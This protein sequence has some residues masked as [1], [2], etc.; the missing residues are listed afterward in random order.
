MMS[1]SSI[2]SGSNPYV[3]N[4]Q[5]GASGLSDLFKQR[6]QDFSTLASA[7]KSGD[8]QGAQ[9]AFASLQ[10]DN[11]TIQQSRGAQGAGGASSGGGDADGDNDGSKSGQAG[12]QGVG[13]QRAKDFA[14]LSSAL[15]SGDLQGA[16]QAFATLQQDIQTSRQGHHHH[17][18]QGTSV[19]PSA[20]TSTGSTA[21]TGSTV[22]V[23]A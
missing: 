20:S 7:L 3:Q 23:T 11:Q 17:H 22:N 16:Q 10:Q 5:S 18:P 6:K 15:G 2:S 4:A 13:G 12:A 19:Q 9:Q 1:I 14:A 8:L 21:S